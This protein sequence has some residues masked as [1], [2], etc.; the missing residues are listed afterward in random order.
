MSLSENHAVESLFL[1][2]SDVNIIMVAIAFARNLSKYGAFKFSK[3]ATNTEKFREN[4]NNWK[5]NNIHHEL[6]HDGSFI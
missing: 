3:I 6:K 4:Q 1:S 5:E 2:L